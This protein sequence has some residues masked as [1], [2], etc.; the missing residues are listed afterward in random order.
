[1]GTVVNHK[2]ENVL[3]SFEDKNENEQIDFV[4][5]T[6]LGYCFGIKQGKVN[7]IKTIISHE[8][9]FDDQKEVFADLRRAFN[10]AN[11]ERYP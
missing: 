2:F 10:E 9:L 3:Y 8:M 4:A 6:S 5:A 7:I 11:M 1:M